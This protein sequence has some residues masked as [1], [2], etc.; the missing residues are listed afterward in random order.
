M[1]D[2]S[3]VGVLENGFE[4]LISCILHHR[5]NKQTGIPCSC[6]VNYSSTTMAVNMEALKN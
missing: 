1:N 3:Q 6:E 2:L 5:Q 4:T